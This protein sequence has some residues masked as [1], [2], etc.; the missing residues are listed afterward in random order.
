MRGGQLDQSLKVMTI[1][2]NT[3]LQ[4]FNTVLLMHLNISMSTLQDFTVSFRK[5][6]KK[7]TK[8]I[9]IDILILFAWLFPDCMSI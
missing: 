8:N 4:L 3:N 2:A 9:Q 6:K 7:I 1:M 5:V